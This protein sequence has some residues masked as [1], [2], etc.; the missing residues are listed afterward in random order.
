MKINLSSV[1]ERDISSSIISANLLNFDTVYV[2]SL[3]Y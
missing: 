1:H 2:K 3:G